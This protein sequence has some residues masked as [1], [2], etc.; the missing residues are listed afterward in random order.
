VIVDDPAVPAARH[1]VGPG[2]FDVLRLPIEAAGGRLDDCRPVDVQFRPG[3]DVIV[4]YTAHVSWQGGPSKRETLVASSTFGGAPD[5]TVVVTADTP[6]GPVD[7]GVW[8][9]PFDPVL[10]GIEHVTSASSVGR[11]LDLDPDDISVEVVAYRPTQRTVIKVSSALGDVVHAYIKVVAPDAVRSIAQRHAALRSAD[12]PAPLVTATDEALGLLVLEPL[13]GPTLRN[14]VKGTPGTWP[15]CDEFDRI[16]D[17]FAATT[18]DAPAVASKLTDAALHARM[19]ALV[20]PERRATLEVLAECFESAP[21]PPS[22]VTIHGDLHDAQLIVV[23]GEIRGVLDVD[24]GGPGAAIDDRAKLIAQL[25]FRVDAGA[26]DAAAVAVADYAESLRHASAPRF[27]A[28]LLDL[29]IAACLVGLATG[30]FQLQLTG[31][32]DT[33]A[34]LVDRASQLAMRELSASPHRGLRTTCAV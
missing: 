23:D 1:L 26:S 5:G 20:A 31:W 4:Q 17:G 34:T 13:V 11:L 22:D 10:R 33:V 6:S 28:D 19:L 2:A 14:L 8:R 15:S 29:H 12:V 18:L 25:L 30:P 16:G 9:W 32:R 7:V 3:S 21:V 27:D 24:D